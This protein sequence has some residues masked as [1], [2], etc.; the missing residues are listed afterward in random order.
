MEKIIGLSG[1]LAS[2]AAFEA[3]LLLNNKPNK[4]TIWL[5]IK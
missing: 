2:V 5:H 3:P 1:S 4:N